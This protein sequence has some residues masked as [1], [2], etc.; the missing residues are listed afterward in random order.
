[1]MQVPKYF[2]ANRRLFLYQLW[3]Q[4]GFFAFGVTIVLIIN[5]FFNDEMN[6]ACMGTLMSLCGIIAGNAMQINNAVFRLTVMMG[7]TRRYYLLWNM[8]LSLTLTVQGWLTAFCLYKLE[9]LLY[10]VL[11]PGW[12]EDLPV[13]MAFH[14]WAVAL[15]A[16][17]VSI[18]CLFFGALYVKFGPKGA[19]T[20][21]LILCLSPVFLPQMVRRF[22]SGDTSP[23]AKLGGLL[24]NAVACLSPVTWAGIGVVLL[25]AML[26]FGIWAYLSA[27]IRM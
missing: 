24:V 22:K 7:E 5:R 27:E 25:L 17:I 8:L 3:Y 6:Y 14:W 21:W 10:S 26:G 16:A 20:F 13:G 4:L 15:S 18:F 1:M 12:L 11:Y 23:L 2:R 9:K 19:L